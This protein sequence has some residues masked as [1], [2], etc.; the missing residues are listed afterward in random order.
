MPST[1][2]VEFLI[3]NTNRSLQFN[4]DN[5]HN[6]QSSITAYLRL[7]QERQP[8]YC[9]SD[10]GTPDRPIDLRQAQEAGVS[11]RQQ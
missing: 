3:G 6:G 5:T 1:R 7:L 8:I 11:A 9:E 2:L 4:R 10:R